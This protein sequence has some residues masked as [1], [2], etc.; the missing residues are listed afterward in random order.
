MLGNIDATE[1]EIEVRRRSRTSGT[2]S[3]YKHRNTIKFL[4]SVSACG[5]TIFVSEAY[6]GRITDEK[7]VDVCGLCD[8][9]EPGQ[10]GMA[11]KGFH[12]AAYLL[13]KAE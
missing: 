9:M 8:V 2:W 11:D 10:V 1:L 13:A 6:P 4:T 12:A 7:L 3:E 5:A